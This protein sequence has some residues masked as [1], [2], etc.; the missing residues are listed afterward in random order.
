MK[1]SLLF[2]LVLMLNLSL[3]SQVSAPQDRRKSPQELQQL[4][5]KY[6]IEFAI[7]KSA[8][9]QKAAQKGWPVRQ[10]FPDGRIIEIMELGP[11]GMPEYN[12]TDNLNAAKTTGT[13]KLWPGGSSGLNLT[14]AGFT[15]GEWD[16]GGVR[17]MHQE[18][19]V[20]AGPSRVTQKDAPGST[21]DH[22]THV[23][24]TLIAE[25]QV[26]NAHGMAPSANLHAYDWD[27]DISEMLN[28]SAID[29]IILSNH[30]YG[31]VRG[32]N[33]SGW[34]YYWSGDTAVSRTEDYQFGFY[35]PLAKTWDSTAYAMQDFLFVKAAGNDRGQS[36]SG[37]HY[38]WD[39]TLDGWVESSWPREMDGG[40]DGYDC[41]ENRGCAKNLLT[42]GAVEDIPGGY[43]APADVVMS[44]FSGWGPTDD[45]RIKPDIVANGIDVYST[46]DDAN[47][48]YTTMSGTSMASPNVCGTLALLQDYHYDL[49]GTYMY[50][51]EL[52]AL[53]VNTA[54]EAG[55]NPGPDYKFGW[56]LLNAEGAADLITLENAEGHHINYY[57]LLHASEIDEYL[58]YSDGSEDINVTIAWVDPP[59]DALPPSLNPSTPHLVHD[60]DVRVVRVSTGANYYP[61]KLNP[62][63]PSAAAFTGDNSRDNIEKV[64]KLS[65]VAGQYKI[66]VSLSGTLTEDQFYAL[67]VSGMEHVGVPGRWTGAISDNWNTAGNWDDGVVPDIT[68]SV[69]IP[70]GCPR[71]PVL[72]GNLGVSYAT[73]MSYVCDNLDV[74]TGG[75]LTIQTYNLYSSGNIDLDGTV[76]VGNDVFLYNGSV[77]DLAGSLYTGYTSSYYGDFIV[78]SGATVNQT[79]GNLRTEMINLVS[80]CQ[81]NGTGGYCRI[82]VEGSVPTI[83]DIQVDD[84]DSYF[85]NFYIEPSANAQLT[86]CGADLD[87]YN[88]DVNGTLTLNNYTITADYADVY[89]TLTIAPGVFDVLENGPYFQEGSVFNMSSGELNGNESIKF[90][91]GAMENVT[92]GEI[93]LLGDF[94][95]EDEVFSPTG[96]SFRFEGSGASNINGPTSFY[97]LYID[98]TYTG[99]DAVENGTGDGAGV[100]ITVSGFLYIQDGSFELNS[101]C[102]LAIEEYL[103]I[104][105]GAAMN[106][107]DTPEILIQIG[108]SW[109]NMNLT[110]GFDAGNSSIVEF[111]SPVS[112]GI[113]SVREN[114]LFNDIIIN[115][116]SPY[117]RPVILEGYS[118]IHA[119]NI[120]INEG[121]LRLSGGKVIVDETLNIYDKVMMNEPLD[122]LVVSDIYWKPVRL[123]AS[124]AAR[125]SSTVPGPGK[126]GPMPRSHRGTWSGLLEAHRNSSIRMMLTPTFITWTLTKALPPYGFILLPHSL[127]MCCII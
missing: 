14:G 34:Y 1:R 2:C 93:T 10:E 31:R 102:T 12:T 44:T 112:L 100:D 90:F 84:A 3:F 67:V 73:G 111:N 68:V 37:T 6:A 22:S 127:S 71:Y 53:V 86:D 47:D 30:S 89:G 91:I 63:T 124:T 41:I 87:I 113:Q 106:A 9:E 50:A 114:N 107:N 60:L 15:I 35:G 125:S 80:G 26:A 76:Y 28:A 36:H 110:G 123:I 101:P 25:G 29:G 69:T 98:K 66:L 65:P 19:R 62:A 79:G 117:I 18:F 119:R 42:V 72:N 39:E 5:S 52:K 54:F 88:I 27:N 46:D 23:A 74:N 7:K 104:S 70:S 99:F 75:I 120:D 103:M 13:N 11:N 83:Q 51:D 121:V 96:G 40:A 16:G 8:A 56:G 55:S 38:V 94:Y 64:T 59:H 45:G 97:N 4:A 43:T 105:E 82:Y 95:D 20:D 116:G 33:Y 32:W 77:M 109:Y 108:K 78:N 85:N 115:S 126:T 21:S 92:G 118:L 122:S 24:G 49:M 58:Y 17:T 57:T 48:D 81:Y 61:W